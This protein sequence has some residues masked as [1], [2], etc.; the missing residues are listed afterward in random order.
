MMLPPWAPALVPAMVKVAEKRL[1]G[2]L[3]AARA[4]IEGRAIRLDDLPWVQQRRLQRLRRAGAAHETADGR[5]YL[6]EPIYAELVAW[7]RRMAFVTILAAILAGLVV[8][9]LPIS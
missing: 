7:R 6:D 2:K 4:T 5:W 8:Y 1:V 9:F 3:R